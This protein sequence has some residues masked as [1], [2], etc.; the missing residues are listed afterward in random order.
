MCIFDVVIQSNSIVGIF[1]FNFWF[2]DFVLLIDFFETGE[3]SSFYSVNLCAFDFFFK[4]R[5]QLSKTYFISKIY[6]IIEKLPAPCAHVCVRVCVC[7]KESVRLCVCVC[8]CVHMHACMCV[9]VCMCV[10]ACLCISFWLILINLAW[11]C[12]QIAVR[13]ALF[14]WMFCVKV[15]TELRVQ[16]YCF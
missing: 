11:F 16:E 1:F 10:C 14:Y 6:Q 15:L 2:V 13:F 12:L 9:C 3:F 8:V 5:W 4:Q 7:V